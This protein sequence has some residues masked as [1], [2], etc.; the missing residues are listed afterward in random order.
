MGGDVVGLTG[1]GASVAMGTV[2]CTEMAVGIGVGTRVAAGT[3]I[4]GSV[5][6]GVGAGALVGVCPAGRRGVG[7]G[8]SVAGTVVEVCAGTGVSGNAIEVAAGAPAVSAGVGSTAGVDCD[9]GWGVGTG[10]SPPPQARETAVNKRTKTETSLALPWSA[11]GAGCWPRSAPKAPLR[12]KYW[13]KIT[14]AAGWAK[15]R[16]LQPPVY[17]PCPRRLR[18]SLRFRERWSY[19]ESDAPAPLINVAPL[20]CNS[21]SR[22]RSRPEHPIR[23]Q[24]GPSRVR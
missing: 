24:P 11:R 7:V 14:L 16:I 4:G 13:R 18:R 21:T 2:D 12:V 5:G 3:G 15:R 20:R 1:V 19:S 6:E 22:L 23:M 8:E 17:S 10:V 9:G